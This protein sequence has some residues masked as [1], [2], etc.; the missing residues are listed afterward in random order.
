MTWDLFG[1]RIPDIRQDWT[2]HGAKDF[3]TLCPFSPH[4]ANEDE[5]A[6][7]LWPSSPATDPSLGRFEA[8]YVG[9]VAEGGFRQEGSSGGMVSWV[10][11]ELLRLGNVDGVA[12][13]V[14][15]PAKSE[16]GLFRYRISRSEAEI[17]E[18]A[19]SR[20]YPV[21]L[22]PVLAE[23]FARPGRYAVV[24]V[25]CFIK[26]INLLREKD[27]VLRQRITH[28]LGLFCGHM[29]SARFVDSIA[30]QI[31]V[32]PEAVTAI[33][34]RVKR[35]EHPANWYRSALSLDGGGRPERDWW[36]LVDGDWGSGFFQNSACDFC[37]DVVGET[38]DISFGD[39]WVEPHSQDGRGTNVVV[40]R[41]PEIG[42]IVRKAITGK[43]LAL[44]PVDADFVIETQAAGFRQRREGLAYRLARFSPRLRPVK[45]VAPTS[46]GLPWRRRLIYRTRRSISF[47]SHRVFVLAHRRQWPGLYL[48]WGRMAATIYHALAYSRGPLGRLLDGIERRNRH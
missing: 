23:I 40:V 37:D 7:R 43:R 44:D 45:R 46:R 41:S 48:A 25:P 27:D 30:W 21:D 14:P 12:H 47:W 31:G 15:S 5:L 9:S 22:A 32:K 20:Y 18:G 26:A 13:V 4:S 16:T 35:P 8:T 11:C 24:G 28:T 36:D 19:R 3:D 42:D 1:Q 34:Y 17:T 29:K 6:E 33:D 38:A 10:A 39:A 2:G